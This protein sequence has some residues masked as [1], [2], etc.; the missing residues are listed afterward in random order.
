MVFLL[1]VQIEELT[2]DISVVTMIILVFVLD[3]CCVDKGGTNQNNETGAFATSFA[4][5]IVKVSLGTV[6]KFGL[7]TVQVDFRGADW[8]GV[9]GR[10]IPFVQNSGVFST[11]SIGVQVNQHVWLGLDDCAEMFTTMTS[12]VMGQGGVFLD[13]DGLIGG[14]VEI[15]LG[16]DNVTTGDGWVG[17]E[18]SP[19]NATDHQNSENNE[20]NGLQHFVQL[21]V[22]LV[23]S[24]QIVRESSQNEAKEY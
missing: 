9:Q 7:E 8:C 16:H 12:W 17:S 24:T 6:S 22:T 15:S 14:G 5:I 18:S 23:F 13:L 11:G 1:L 4:L 10:R 2:T 20:K 19:E 3:V 21:F